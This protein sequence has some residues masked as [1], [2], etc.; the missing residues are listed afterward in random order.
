M[1]IGHWALGI[2]HWAL[3]IGHWLLI[4]LPH[5]SHLPLLPHLLL[6]LYPLTLPQWQ[7][8]HQRLKTGS[9]Q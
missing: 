4:L 7:Q 2:G 8:R 6:P 9:R 5:L 3:G 1:G